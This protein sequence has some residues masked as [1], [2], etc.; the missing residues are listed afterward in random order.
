MT[1]Q[2]FAQAALF[3]D[4][5]DLEVWDGARLEAHFLSK[6]LVRAASSWRHR[7][8]LACDR[9]T[10]TSRPSDLKLY[11][12]GLYGSCRCGRWGALII[13]T[14]APTIP[15][16]MEPNRTPFL[17]ASWR[18]GELGKASSPMNRLIVKPMPQI[19]E[20]P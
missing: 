16:T 4:G 5:H 1:K 6:T 19:R 7:Q 18:T 13:R 2:P 15:E 9:E 12:P 10:A 3:L 20:T 11:K 17:T 14:A 8:R